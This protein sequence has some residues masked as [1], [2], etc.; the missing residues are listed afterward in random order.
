M[1]QTSFMAYNNLPQMKEEAPEKKNTGMGLLSRSKDAMMGPAKP[2]T[3]IERVSK[4][5]SNIRSRRE[6]LKTNV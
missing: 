2:K 4:Y 6:A 5:V 3:E 1:F